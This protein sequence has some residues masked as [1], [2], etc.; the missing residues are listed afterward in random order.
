MSK[1]IL[2]TKVNS[3]TDG[4]LEWVK[5][6]PSLVFRLCAEITDRLFPFA[7]APLITPMA[8]IGW[9]GF[10]WTWFSIAFLWRLLRDCSANR[11]SLGKRW[12][13]LRV[14]STQGT[15]HLAWQRVIARQILPALSQSA[16]CI[17]IAAFIIGLL[18]PEQIPCPWRFLT[19]HVSLLLLLAFGYDVASLTSILITDGGRRIEDFIV[20]ARVV[21]E[22][23]YTRNR[24]KCDACGEMILKGETY[25]WR[26]GERNAPEIKIRSLFDPD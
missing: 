3:Q 4:G 8:L 11:R 6:R 23:A 24:K 14:V 7:I 10:F 13:R 26:C 17:A 15:R 22:S 19:Q 1:Q 18:P 21:S 5:A 16:Y 20:G 25:C 12:F 2:R 9:S